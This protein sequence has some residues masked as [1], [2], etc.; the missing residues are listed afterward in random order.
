MDNKFK[1]NLL[2]AISIEE[3]EAWC[4]TIFEQ[5]NTINAADP[6]KK[7]QTYLNRNNFTYKKLKLDPLK[8]KREYFEAFTRKKGFQKIKK[9]KQYA[10]YN[11]SLK[12]FIISVEQRVIK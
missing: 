3:I 2:F 8:H 6:K 12:D 9:L 11:E 1:E 7:L 10:E 5:K 4:L